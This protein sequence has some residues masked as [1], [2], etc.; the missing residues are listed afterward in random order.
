MLKLKEEL[1][2]RWFLYQKSSDEVFHLFDKWWEKF[3]CWFDP[4]ADSLH[5]WNFVGFMMW[6]HLMKR[7]NKYFAL[8]W[9][10]TWMIWDPGW[11]DAERTFLSEKSL[12]DNEES[13]WKQIG[14]IL[15]HLED[16]IWDK[17]NFKLKYKI[18]NNYDFFKNMLFLEFLREVWKF[19]T[20]NNMIWKDTVKKRIEDRDKSISYTEFSY[21]LLQW[22]DFYHL[23]SKEW[24]KLQ[25]WGQD[26]WW[27]LMTW[28]ELIRKKTPWEWFAITFP[29][30]LDSTWKKFWKSEW[31][32]L[33]LDKDKTSS[34]TLYQY[35]MNTN[36][37][38]VERFLKIL[39]LIPLEK[40]EEI[41]KEHNQDKEKRIGQKEL[42]YRVV[43]IIHW[44]EEAKTSKKVSEFLFWDND[45][46]DLLLNLSTT[47]LNTLTSEV[48]WLDEYDWE[49]LF[50]VIVKTWLA[51]SN[52]EA[53]QYVNSGAIFINEV[54]ISQMNYDFKENF[55]DNSFIIIRKGKKNFRIIRK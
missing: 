34:Y 20:V 2:L 41:V 28:V 29:L 55:I 19:I 31:N 44:K 17:H 42:A 8:I 9:W 40:I 11:K 51:K 5:L 12:R 53:R 49:N 23:Y 27:N 10:A 52:S 6:V 4:T 37:E 3:Y 26:Q 25:I 47:E 14:N 38:D 1:E 22:Y 16:V 30:L 15:N 18:V 46:I 54:K 36:D 45:K 33:W 48:W 21:M 50:E 39:T 32:A 24:V 7:D 35:F 13:I 43:E